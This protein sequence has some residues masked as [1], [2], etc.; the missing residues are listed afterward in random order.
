MFKF[1]FNPEDGEENR[2]GSEQAM[3]D[4]A[5]PTG[6]P[7]KC[8]IHE[9]T[10]FPEDLLKPDSISTLDLENGHSLKFVKMAK[11]IEQMPTKPKYLEGIIKEKKPKTDYNLEKLF[12]RGL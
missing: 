12:F 5:Y 11:A 7:D 8:K 6:S 2:T 9:P 3:D 4:P 1:N 10:R